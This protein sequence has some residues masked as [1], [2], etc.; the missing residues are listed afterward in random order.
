MRRPALSLLLS[1]FAVCVPLLF[2]QDVNAQTI[3]AADASN[4]VGENATV[5]GIVASAKYSA[6]SKGRPTFLNLDK[7]Y[8][9]QIFTALIWGSDRMKF[10]QP[11]LTYRGKRICVSGQIKVYRRSPEIVVRNPRQ[12]GVK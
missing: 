8:P 12:I 10:G 2:A 9:R 4:H 7:A 5:C 1:T 3:S 6:R 11:E